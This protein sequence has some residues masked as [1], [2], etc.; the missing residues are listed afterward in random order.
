[1]TRLSQFIDAAAVTLAE[2][3]VPAPRV[4]AELLAAHVAGADRGRLPLIDAGPDFPD[5]YDDLITR[6]ARR[7]PLQHLVGTA[8]FG[9][10]E[11]HVGPGVFIPRPETEALL[12]WAM[13][14]NLPENPVVVDLCTGTG[15]LALALAR[16]LPAAR[17]LAVDDSTR[18]LEYARCNVAGTQVELVEVDVTAPGLLPE[19]DGAVDLV[20]AN[21]PYIPDGAALEPEVAEHDPAHALFGGPDGMRVIDAITALAARW[22][23]DDG[24]CAVEHDDTTSSRTV[25]SFTRTGAFDDITA[26]LDLAGRPRF[27]TARRAM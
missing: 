27:V 19:L 13:T 5:R 26:R 23:V 24:F 25:E 11:V 7:I 4:D 12:E 2:A 3:G 17:V 8:P 6:R 9:P 1:M 22:L 20:V 16:H 21:P 14:R 18:A 15:A 10:V